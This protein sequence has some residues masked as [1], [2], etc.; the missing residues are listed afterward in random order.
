MAAE[1]APTRAIGFVLRLAHGHDP[2]QVIRRGR[3]QTQEPV[4]LV[5]VEVLVVAVAT[6]VRGSIIILVPLELGGLRVTLRVNLV[7][8]RCGPLIIPGMT[9]GGGPRW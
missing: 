4:Q 2:L 6:L 9:C 7:V 8:T 5:Y 1:C 3:K